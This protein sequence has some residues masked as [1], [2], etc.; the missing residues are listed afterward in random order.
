MLPVQEDDGVLVSLV[1]RAAAEAL[2]S[3]HGG[4]SYAS[5]SVRTWLPRP[6]ADRASAALEPMLRFESSVYVRGRVLVN[7][8][9][10]GSFRVPTV[11]G[12]P[13]ALWAGVQGTRIAHWDVDVANES[14]SC[15]PAPEAWVD[16]FALRLEVARNA[17]GDFVVDLNGKV[18]LLEAPPQPVELE[19][20]SRLTVDHIRSRGAFFDELRTLPSQG[21]RVSFGGGVAIELEVVAPGDN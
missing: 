4:T 12:R 11:A 5:G 13:L 20:E 9:E 3:G 16:G 10:R 8:E 17:T 18:C 19:D 2:E 6:F 1:E 15:N 7:G 14:Q 21:G